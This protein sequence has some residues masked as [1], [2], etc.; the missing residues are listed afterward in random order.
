MQSDPITLLEFLEQAGA[1]VR[2][3]DIGRRIGAL[4]RKQFLAFE[5][6]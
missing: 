6:A 5:N 1:T 3:Y 2:T 4:G